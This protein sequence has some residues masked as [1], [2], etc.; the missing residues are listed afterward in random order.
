MATAGIIAAVAFASLCAATIR[1]QAPAQKSSPKWPIVPASL[2]AFNGVDTIGAVHVQHLHVEIKSDRSLED[3]DPANASVELPAD[4]PAWKSLQIAFIPQTN[5]TLARFGGLDLTIK[6]GHVWFTKDGNQ[7]DI[8]PI[9]DRALNDIQLVKHLDYLLAYV[10]GERAN[11]TITPTSALLPLQV[12]L[13]TWK[14]TI[15]GVAGYARELTGDEVVAN[16]HGAKALSKG[17]FGDTRTVTVEADLEA[18]TL[19]PEPD[20]IAPN[21]SALVAEEY[22]IVTIVSGRMSALKP[23]LKI[24][25]FRWG[26][27]DGAVTDLA[28]AK[29]GDHANM[30]IQPLSADKKYEKE[31]QVDTLDSDINALYFVDV[32][33]STK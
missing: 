9:H 2:F 31:V 4:S 30:V 11:Q 15:V 28:K 25:V 33:P 26:I 27:R 24:R 23:G 3:R 6:A 22:T 18:I 7:L 17:L 32:T 13:D 10:N 19:V 16:Q 12:G 1:P 29:V 14:G 21:R 8:A 20:S 5:G